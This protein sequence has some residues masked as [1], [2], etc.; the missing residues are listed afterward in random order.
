MNEI[1]NPVHKHMGDRTHAMN[2][3]N[4]EDTQILGE[5]VDINCGGKLNLKSLGITAANLRIKAKRSLATET[6]D[7]TEALHVTNR[8]E[9]DF[10][11]ST[12][13]NQFS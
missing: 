9:L 7:Y 4:S 1:M 13:L 8:I 12:N 2:D 6:T 5:N 10:D 3:F 11:K